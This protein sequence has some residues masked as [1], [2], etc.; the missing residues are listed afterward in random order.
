MAGIRQL[1]FPT[2]PISTPTPQVIIYNLT[3][4]NG[5]GDDGGGQS[6]LE[7]LTQ[8]GLDSSIDRNL[9]KSEEVANGEAQ[10]A[11][12][13]TTMTQTTGNKFANGASQRAFMETVKAS[14]SVQQASHTQPRNSDQTR[15]AVESLQVDKTKANPTITG[16]TDVSG[17][18]FGGIFGVSVSTGLAGDT[19]NAKACALVTACVQVGLGVFVGAGGSV[20][21]GVSKTPLSSGTSE[22]VGAFGNIGAFGTAAGGS[23]NFGGGSAGGAKGF[24]GVGAGISGG[25]QFCRSSSKCLSD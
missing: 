13:S 2:Q 8:V 23:V 10:V 4:Q 15:K 5:E 25:L 3:G 19:L 20:G 9:A 24:V 18:V 1:L 11:T 6:P 14:N 22:S 7:V 21:A 16:S 17:Q 12:V